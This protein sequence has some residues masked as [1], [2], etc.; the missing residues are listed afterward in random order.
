MCDPV[1]RFNENLCG[2][3]GLAI[4]CARSIPESKLG[5]PHNLLEFGANF[6]KS[7]N[8]SKAIE[9]FIERTYHLWDDAHRK[10]N[11]F[12]VNNASTAFGE[13]P[14]NGGKIFAKIWSSD[15]V[16]SSDRDDMWIYFHNLIKNCIRYMAITPDYEEALTVP[17][18]LK[19]KVAV[20]DLPNVNPA[21]LK[22][23]GSEAVDEF[24]K[25]SSTW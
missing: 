2:M 3:I 12:I 21:L 7:I 13:I 23:W 1:K 16:P 8:P 10:D 9:G 18:C 11:E 4:D 24:R 15:V 5:V 14:M 20:L 25:I 19:W 6:L 22:V 17:V